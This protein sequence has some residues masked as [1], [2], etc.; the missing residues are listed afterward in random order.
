MEC[1]LREGRGL[2]STE[3]QPHILF[4][5]DRDMRFTIG[6]RKRH[7]TGSSRGSGIPNGHSMGTF[8]P[9]KTLLAGVPEGAIR[10]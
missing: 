10:T 1:Y 9:E 4:G 7:S 8:G 3:T 5:A 2:W 6:S